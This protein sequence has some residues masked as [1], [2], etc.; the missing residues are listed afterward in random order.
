MSERKSTTTTNKTPTQPR[1]STP[2]LSQNNEEPQLSI[3][4]IKETIPDHIR[5][6]IFD[7]SLVRLPLYV[8]MMRNFNSP[9]GKMP[10]F[11]PIIFLE[12][13]DAKNFIEKHK[14]SITLDGWLLHK[15]LSNARIN[16][17]LTEAENELLNTSDV[18]NRK[19]LGISR[20]MKPMG[21]RDFVGIERDKKE[22]EKEDERKENRNIKKLK[23]EKEE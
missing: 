6:E 11:K 13:E 15:D 3:K 18:Y 10:E 9:I 14:E 22:K 23:V 17:S 2:P 20:G 7:K 21:L 12:E 8:V 4:F 5:C 1:P 19:P 16:T